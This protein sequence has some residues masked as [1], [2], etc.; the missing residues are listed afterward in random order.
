MRTFIKDC[1]NSCPPC[2][3][4]KA[5]RHKLYGFLKQLPIPSCPWNSISMDS[6][7]HLPLS[8]GFTAI[9]VIVNRLTEQ[10]IF[11]LTYDT[12]TVMQLVELFI[13]HVFSK[14]GVPSHVTSDRGSKFISH[15]FQSLEKALDMN[16]HFTLGY[17]L[18][19]DGQTECVN[20]WQ[21]VFGSPVTK[22][23]K[24]CNRTEP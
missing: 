4:S 22:L 5:P 7:E 9:L 2:R 23:E 24:D 15:F 16:L 10:G 19:G 20:H 12:I 6:I 1:C 13:L 14:H 17:H 8:L 11:I 18:E 3:R 21:I